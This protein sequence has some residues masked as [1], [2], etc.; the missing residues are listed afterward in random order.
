MHEF[1]RVALT[2]DLPRHGLSAGNVGMIVHVFGDH[3][4]YAVEFVTF[5]SDLVALAS[6]YSQQIRPLQNDEI[7]SARR[8]KTV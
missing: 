5:S 8:V 1:E 3:K 2:H 6:V 4:G 7:A